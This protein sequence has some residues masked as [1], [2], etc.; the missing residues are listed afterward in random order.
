MLIDFI[1][2]SAGPDDPAGGG[3]DAALFI[4]AKSNPTD[5]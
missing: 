3:L 4:F 5:L 2:C 1:V